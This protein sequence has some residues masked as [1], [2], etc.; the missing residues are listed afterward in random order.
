MIS[1]DRYTIP[2]T[3]EGVELKVGI[4]DV[5]LDKYSERNDIYIDDFSI[6]SIYDED[7]ALVVGR[8]R[9]YLAEKLYNNEDFINELFEREM[10]YQQELAVEHALSMREDR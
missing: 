10:Q 8:Y 7:D 9:D 1:T 6:G 2:F 4:A 5:V 3:I